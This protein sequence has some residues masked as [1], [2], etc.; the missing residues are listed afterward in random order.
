LDLHNSSKSNAANGDGVGTCNQIAFG[1]EEIGAGRGRLVNTVCC[2]RLVNEID[3]QRA[4]LDI[5][6]GKLDLHSPRKLN[7]GDSDEV[8]TQCQRLCSA[9]DVAAGRVRLV[10]FGT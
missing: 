9:E 2:D 8:F 5:A 1:G 4:V 6:R 10:K 3:C 7:C